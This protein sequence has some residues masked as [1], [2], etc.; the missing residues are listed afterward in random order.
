MLSIQVFTEKKSHIYVFVFFKK[1]DARSAAIR[2]SSL[3]ARAR[4]EV[5]AGT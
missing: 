1:S 4:P 2:V 3:A 5:I